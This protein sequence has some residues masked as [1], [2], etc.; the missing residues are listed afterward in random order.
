MDK[1]FHRDAHDPAAVRAGYLY[2][3][4][5]IMEFSHTHWGGVE[6]VNGEE[7]LLTPVVGQKLQTLPGS[8]DH[9]DK[10]YRSPSIQ[11]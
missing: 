9:P 1:R 7:V 2:S 11:N 3:D 5:S 6:M 8:P 4:S 10:G